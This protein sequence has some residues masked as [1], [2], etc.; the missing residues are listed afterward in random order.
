[1]AHTKITV[2]PKGIEC[3][4][5]IEGDILSGGSNGHGSDEPEWAEVVGLTMTRTDGCALPRRTAA[6]IAKEYADYAAT[7]LYESEH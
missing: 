7:A 6:L 2:Y 3:T 5:T 1:M 4:I